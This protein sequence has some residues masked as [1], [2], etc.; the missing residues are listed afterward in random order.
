MAK[1]NSFKGED[2]LLRGLSPEDRNAFLALGVVKAFGAQEYIIRDGTPGDA[3]YIL[4]KGRVSIWKDDVKLGELSEGDVFGEAVI[5]HPHNRIACVRT[6][7]PSEV[8]EFKR[9]ELLN[10]FKWREEKLFKYFI[11]NIISLLLD[12]L[13]RANERI[14]HLEHT[15]REQIAWLVGNK[16]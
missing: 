10:F 9:D 5:L 8:L 16:G 1:K 4:R 3:L 15:F 12:K 14:I 6:E 13:N 11:L 2:I 7:R